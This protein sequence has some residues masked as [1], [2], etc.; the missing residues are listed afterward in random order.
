[1]RAVETLWEMNLFLAK[2]L[3]H[4]TTDCLYDFYVSIIDLYDFR[5]CVFSKRG[6][7]FVT[8]LFKNSKNK[9]N[10]LWHYVDPSN[11]THRPVFSYVRAYEY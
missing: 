6:I 2:D 11:D 1:M 7:L 8:V 10:E 9:K 3:A 4:Y 5:R